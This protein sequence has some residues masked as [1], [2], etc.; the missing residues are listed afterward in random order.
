MTSSELILLLTFLSAAAALIVSVVQ[1]T[2]D[3]AWKI[4]HDRAWD[5]N[6]KSK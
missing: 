4:S 6:K 3:I 2:F 5:D 1:A